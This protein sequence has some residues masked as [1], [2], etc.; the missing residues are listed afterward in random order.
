MKKVQSQHHHKSLLIV[1]PLIIIVFAATSI[2][3]GPLSANAEDPPYVSWGVQYLPVGSASAYHKNVAGWAGGE[4]TWEELI[5][6]DEYKLAPNAGDKCVFL[7][8]GFDLYN[9]KTK[10]GDW[11][12]S[13]AKNKTPET[14]Y[15]KKP[16]TVKVGDTLKVKML[17]V[18]KGVLTNTIDEEGHWL[19]INVKYTKASSS[20]VKYKYRWVVGDKDGQNGKLIKGAT[21]ATYKVPAKYKGKAIWVSVQ[22]VKTGYNKTYSWSAFDWY[23][24]VAK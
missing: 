17:G 2:F 16:F 8:A 1:I 10:I 14:Y 3:T 7:E 5:K 9:G 23:A 24:K 4:L 12:K 21:K 6:V 15:K 11:K 22:S 20:G 18:D 13:H 19:K